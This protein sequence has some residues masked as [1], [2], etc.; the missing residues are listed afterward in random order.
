[1][2][3]FSRLLFGGEVG[4]TGASVLGTPGIPPLAHAGAHIL[5]TPLVERRHARAHLGDP[6]SREAVDLRKQVTSGARTALEEQYL[7]LLARTVQAC[8]LEARLGGDP[9]IANHVWAFLL[10]R[11]YRGGE[12]QDQIEVSL[13]QVVLVGTPD[14]FI[15]GRGPAAMGLILSGTHWA[16][17][18]SS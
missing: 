14:D 9:S 11:F 17:E 7:D 13:D 8:P 3:H 6:M 10:I 12:W 15:V 5:N 16:C 1:M 2:G 18:G 4:D